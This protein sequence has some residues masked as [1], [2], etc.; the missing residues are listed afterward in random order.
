LQAKPYHRDDFSH[1]STELLKI[2]YDNEVLVKKLTGIS[3]Q[4]PTWVKDAKK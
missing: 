2:G 3:M 1:S 4:P